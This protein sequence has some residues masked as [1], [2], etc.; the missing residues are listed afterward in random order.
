MIRTTHKLLRAQLAFTLIETM[1]ATLIIAILISLLMPAIMKAKSKGFQTFCSNNLKGVGLGLI[2]YAE[3]NDGRFPQQV[4]A[5]QGGCAPMA[6]ST[7]LP[8][9]MVA[10]DIR[11]FIIASNNLGNT[12]ILICPR[13]R[14]LRVPAS[15]AQVRSTNVSYFTAVRPRRNNHNTILSGD[16]NITWLPSGGSPFGFR[17]YWSTN[18]HDDNG[19]LVF[20]DGRV[21]GVHKE[22]LGQIF[23][24]AARP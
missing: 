23:Y 20:S 2:S 6:A 19:N 10:R 1:V 9:G 15:F 5:Q 18:R 22:K 8:G 3:S 17:P 7:F 21:E 12:K 16:N 13:D 11:P 24:T 4:P 14:E